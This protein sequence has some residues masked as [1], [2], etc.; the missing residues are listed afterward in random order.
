MS[1]QAI[2]TNSSKRV[3]TNSK[4]MRLESSSIKKNKSSK[5]LNFFT[6][7]DQKSL[8]GKV[9]ALTGKNAS[10][11]QNALSKSKRLSK[12]ELDQKAS[13][14]K[15][16][17]E[18]KQNTRKPKISVSKGEERKLVN[19]VLAAA[20]ANLLTAK[21]NATADLAPNASDKAKLQQRIDRVFYK[22]FGD[23]A[24]PRG[25]AE[26][27]ETALKT[28]KQNELGHQQWMSSKQNALV[29]SF[30][31]MR[32]LKRE[33]NKDNFNPVQG[34]ALLN[35]IVT[36]IKNEIMLGEKAKPVPDVRTNIGAFMRGIKKERPVSSKS[37]LLAQVAAA[38]TALN[39]QAINQ[40]LPG[41][42]RA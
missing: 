37:N 16:K 40:N 30:N 25:F 4:R 18:V 21:K 11:A 8:I 6:K 3:N 36:N 10:Q 26:Q 32:K 27:L 19:R 13:K 2:N 9:L 20:H 12:A 1:I 34:E 31:K 22:V 7:R 42:K 38:K 17:I 23:K 24:N 5:V 14:P 41:I 29:K 15:A 35:T 28:H 33:I 39:Q